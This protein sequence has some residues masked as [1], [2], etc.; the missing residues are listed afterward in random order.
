[1]IK[2]YLIVCPLCFYMLIAGPWK[3]KQ[4]NFQELYHGAKVVAELIF[5]ESILMLG[6]TYPG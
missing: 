6:D 1:M 2:T 5:Q 3:L 4:I